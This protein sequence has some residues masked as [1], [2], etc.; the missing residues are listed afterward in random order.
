MLLLLQRDNGGRKRRG[1]FLPDETL[2]WCIYF[3]DNKSNL[4]FLLLL[5]IS[6]AVNAFKNERPNFVMDVIKNIQKVGDDNN[7]LKNNWCNSKKKKSFVQQSTV[8]PIL[9]FATFANL[10]ITSQFFFYI[11]TVENTKRSCSNFWYLYFCW[12]TLWL[13]ELHLKSP[14]FDQRVQ[15]VTRMKTALKLSEFLS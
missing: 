8:Y 12:R 2:P 9:F 15:K 6:S 3:F 11:V 4:P 13:T 5:I 1:A 10:W 7:L 14:F